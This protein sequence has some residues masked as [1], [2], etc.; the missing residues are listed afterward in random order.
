M[1]AFDGIPTGEIAVNLGETIMAVKETIDAALEKLAHA[2][3]ES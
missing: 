1:A 2:S 3:H